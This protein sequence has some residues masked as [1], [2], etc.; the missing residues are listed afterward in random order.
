MLK[1]YK[2]SH[3]DDQAERYGAYEKVS[4]IPLAVESHPASEMNTWRRFGIW[5]SASATSSASS[6][7]SVPRTL[8]G[9]P[10]R[11]TNR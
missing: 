7:I 10:R 11:A 3:L 6:M 2:H 9:I 4:S 8:R 1:F 5:L